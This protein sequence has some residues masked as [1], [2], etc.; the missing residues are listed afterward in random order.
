MV[1]TTSL[2]NQYLSIHRKY[3]YN[4]FVADIYLMALFIYLYCT[5]YNNFQSS[6]L[7]DLYVFKNISVYIHNNI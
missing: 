7:K 5:N 2:I 6:Y 3:K 1:Q 4:N